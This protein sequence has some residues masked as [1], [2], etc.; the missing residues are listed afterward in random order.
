MSLK[1]PTNTRLGPFTAPMPQF[2]NQE[3]NPFFS[4]I[5]QNMELSHGP[6]RERLPVRLPQECHLD[7]R[8]GNV[9]GHTKNPRCLQGVS[10]VENGVFVAPK[11]L[12][13]IVID[14]TGPQ[15]LAEMYEVI[16]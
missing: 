2:E 4:N 16:R 13:D 12:R 9:S 11:W 1:L 15:K 7:S 8:I 5:R 10:H 3:F 6:I 14:G